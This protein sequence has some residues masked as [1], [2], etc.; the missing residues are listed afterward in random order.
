VQDCLNLK[1]LGAPK[2]LEREMANVVSIHQGERPTILLL[3]NFH[4]REMLG[5]FI[6]MSDRHNLVCPDA[7]LDNRQCRRGKKA[8]SSQFPVQ[9][10]VERILTSSFVVHNDKERFDIGPITTSRLEDLLCRLGVQQIQD[11]FSAAVS[12]FGASNES[13]LTSSS[14]LS[15]TA[16]RRRQQLTA[17]DHPTGGAAAEDSDN[18]VGNTLDKLDSKGFLFFCSRKTYQECADLNL[19][20]M[21]EKQIYAMQ[22][23][24][25]PGTTPVFLF[26]FS[27]RKMHGIFVATSQ[28]GLNLVPNAF[29]QGL[30]EHLEPSV[31]CAQVN[32]QKLIG[33]SYNVDKMD[34]FDPGS[35]SEAITAQVMLKCSNKIAV[36]P[37]NRNS[38]QTE[39]DRASSGTGKQS[40]G[41]V[42]CSKNDQAC[43]QHKSVKEKDVRAMAVSSSKQQ[44]ASDK[45]PNKAVSKYQASLMTAVLSTAN[46]MQR[47]KATIPVASNIQQLGMAVPSQQHKAASRVEVPKVGGPSMLSNSTIQTALQELKGLETECAIPAEAKQVRQERR[48]D[49]EAVAFRVVMVDFIP[50]GSMKA[51]VYD[52]FSSVGTIEMLKLIVRPKQRF[53]PLRSSTSRSSAGL[54]CK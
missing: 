2:R 34:R 38:R 11:V 27:R 16:R 54:Y 32:V 1:L 7:F 26:D 36:Q 31:F 37:Q 13:A 21:R 3:F 6:A 19:F 46:N 9:L 47:S 20:A 25:N 28:P 18:N 23:N 33:S 49:P 52:L 5:V 8:G 48:K 42:L 15:H 4:K 12:E 53:G 17:R 29:T 14:K 51:E 10:N 40:N 30:G 45:V 50:I 24:I 22:K 39:V 35:M 43:L 44:Y 41:R